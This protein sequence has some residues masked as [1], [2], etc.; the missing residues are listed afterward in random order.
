MILSMIMRRFEVRLFS[1]EA[2]LGNVEQLIS[3]KLYNNGISDEALKNIAWDTFQADW[4]VVAGW[5]L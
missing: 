1:Q 3:V 5:R 2:V 4:F